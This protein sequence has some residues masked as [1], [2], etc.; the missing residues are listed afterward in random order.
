MA[1]LKPGKDPANSKSFRL[2]ALLSQSTNYSRLILNRLV[3]FVDQHLITEQAGFR[4]GKSCISQ[5]LNLT[6]FFEDGHEKESITG[7]SLLD[8][9]T[10]INTINH[11]ILMQKLFQKTKYVRLTKLIA[12][13]LAS[14]C[15]FVDLQC[16]CGEDPETMEHLL[17]CPLLP[18]LCGRSM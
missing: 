9:S 15:F 8:L 7:A 4:P 2:I 6:L 14:R 18:Q 12:H 1:T 17:E 11:R 13:M 10:A 5:L 3:S 16:D